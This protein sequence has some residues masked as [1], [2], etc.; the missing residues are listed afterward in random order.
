MSRSR[1][2]P[3]QNPL[4]QIPALGFVLC[5]VLALLCAFLQWGRP[6]V[7][8]AIAL[9]V[10]N[11]TGSL[12]E[13]DNPN[14]VIAKEIQAV[15]SYIQQ[16]ETLAKKPNQLQ[17]FGF[18]QA[19]LPLT[20]GFSSD[21]DQLRQEL[22]QSLNNPRLGSRFLPDSTDLNVAISTGIDALKNTGD[23][24]RELLLVTDGEVT[25]DPR[26]IGQALDNRVKINAVVVDNQAPLL[27]AA[28]LAT[29][30]H[31]LEGDA[32]SLGRLFV[33]NFFQL[34]NSNRRWVWYALG[35][36]WIFLM[37]ML[38]LPLDVWV[39]QRLSDRHNGLVN[40]LSLFHAFFW[41][42]LTPLILYRLG[43]LPFLGPC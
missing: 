14:S 8:V 7:S 5:C 18:G 28:A 9:D 32:L 16:N 27:A 25:V 6:A 34:F 36:A 10:S 26:V 42:A 35:M 23:R 41:T 4:F 13:K 29:R 40:R 21:G 33:D 38:V 20:T 11:S 17:I 37:W 3:F 19:T 2:S 24:C 31:Y 43:S 12:T 1:R 15:R 30:G 39:I 22:N